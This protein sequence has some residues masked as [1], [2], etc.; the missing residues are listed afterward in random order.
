MT[1]KAAPDIAVLMPVYNPGDELKATLDSLRAQ[2][3]PFRLFLVDDGSKFQTDYETLTQG[4]DTR[5]IRLP[6]N[7]GI[8][9]AMN[10]G[11]EEIL[12]SSYLY[13]A[14]IDTGDFCTPERFSKQKTY[15]DVHPE[16]AIL[17]SDVELR[18]FNE[19]NELWDTRSV[20]YPKSP[21]ECR[22]Q[23][24]F[25][26]PVSHPAVIIRRAVFESLGGY[27]EAYPAAE[28]FDLMWRA[29]AA[30]FNIANLADILL[31]KEE[32]PGSIS[33]KRRRRQVFSRLRI[34]WANR[35]LASPASLIGLARSTAMLLAPAA[36]I[37]A[38]KAV[39]NK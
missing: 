27:S 9:G 19:L 22:K 17:G 18:K 28:D 20:V 23:L 11:L 2:S 35:N 37:N 25:N 16:I 12:K 34:Q 29:S 10:A 7:L 15:L 26:S 36:V 24:F 31:I 32:N 21:E 14:R 13:I 30:G 5:I 1:T 4:I 33:Q 6:Q 3:V 39:L 8:S 38:L